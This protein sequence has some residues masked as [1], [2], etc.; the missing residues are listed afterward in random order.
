MD[1]PPD[2]SDARLSQTLLHRM[3]GALYATDARGRLLTANAA[4]TDLLGWTS[5]ELLDQVSPFCFWAPESIDAIQAE[6]NAA[7]GSAN[8]SGPKLFWKLMNKSGERISVAVRLSKFQDEK[9][10][11]VG[12]IVLIDPLRAPEGPSVPP[13][14]H[15]KFIEAVMRAAPEAIYVHDLKE[16]RNVY[17]NR[18]V[19]ELLGHTAA[20]IQ[21]MGPD[22]L[23][24][25]LH[26][27]DLPRIYELFARWNDA[28]DGAVL[29]TEYRML[30]STG[31]YRWFLSRDTIFQRD[32]AGKVVQLI[33][34]AQDITERKKAEQAR[35]DAERHLRESERRYRLLADNATDLISRHDADTGVFFDV[36]PACSRLLGYTPH[37][38]IGKT[39]YEIIHPADRDR[40]Y[41]QQT[42]MKITKRPQTVS[43]RVRRHDN[44]YVWFETHAQPIFDPDTDEVKEILAIS[45]EV[46]DRRQAEEALR[47]SEELF[48]A[49]VEKSSDGIAMIGDDSRIRYISPSASRL[50][51]YTVAEMSG[52]DARQLIDANDLTTFSREAAEP[53]TIPGGTFASQLRVK[54]CEGSYRTLEVIVT[55]HSGDAAIAGFIVNFRDVSDRIALE[56]QLRQAQK[57]EAVGQLAGG[58][59]H[60][61]N[62]IL[63]AVIG[64]VAML[65]EK[66]KADDPERQTLVAVD[67]AAHRAAD[68][69][70]RLLGYARWTTLHLHSIDL[71]RIVTDVLA[72][73]R[74]TIDPRILIE[75][76]IDSNGWPIVADP[77]QIAQVLTNLCLN[78][79]DAMPD[80]GRLILKSCNYHV[81]D[82]D[83][84]KEQV[85]RF[86]DFVRLTISDT[87]AGMTPDVLARVFEPFF[88]TKPLGHGTGLGLAMVYGIL[89]AHD[90]W[91][92]CHSK[93]GEGT[94][95]ELYLPRSTK[96]AEG[97][98][99]KDQKATPAPPAVA[100]TELIL[101]VDDEPA[102]RSLGRFVLEQHG[103][104]VV[105]AEDGMEAVEIYRKQGGQIALVVLD[106]TMPRL[107]GMDAYRRLRN[108]NPHVRVLLSSGYSPDHL[109]DLGPLVGFINKPYRPTEFVEA[110]RRHLQVQSS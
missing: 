98:L 83:V 39:S 81:S 44:Y 110:V 64:N 49:L 105:L 92:T 46:T 68:L 82:A 27:D 41:E 36:T 73:L 22:V 18:N 87:G 94:R 9:S 54:T 29:E 34:A 47:Q 61:F 24:R 79:R 78:A 43:Y 62:N 32:A 65:L 99:L 77:D 102:I 60:D 28:K 63:T 42:Q 76:S 59:A 40:V 80:G 106:L 84:K 101:L 3:P 12:L 96:P 33:G 31:E 66:R 93:V 71:S 16:N 38:L 17:A 70:S 1:S 75:D 30:A 57:M 74:P 11:A 85:G 25:L 52:I 35:A 6:C 72:L 95:M 107:S 19:A 108:M 8:D 69:T 91:A 58:I 50:L 53:L 37:E 67:Q 88:T 103:Y 10:D 4:F 109:G 45:R 51:G 97:S 20:E 100:P 21:A 15:E 56:A 5:D 14:E 104:R 26:P 55:N 90:G 89:K 23:P 86:G 7:I 2:G 13:G 48:R